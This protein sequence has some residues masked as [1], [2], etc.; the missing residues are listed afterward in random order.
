LLITIEFL[1]K[2]SSRIKQ[3]ISIKYE[4]IYT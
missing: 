1:I 4:Y 2:N 3:V